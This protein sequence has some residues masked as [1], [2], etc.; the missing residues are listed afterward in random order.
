[1]ISLNGPSVV[2]TL[3]VGTYSASLVDAEN[4]V[5]DYKVFI[6]SS[7][8]TS[9]ASPLA[10]SPINGTVTPENN[11]FSFDIT[12]PQAKGE[13][14]IHINCTSGSYYYNKVHKIYV[15]TP[16]SFSVDVNNPTNVEIKNAT[17]QFF[18][19]D[20]E[21]DKQVILSLGA[22]QSTQV[23]SEW[24]SKDK[25]PGWHTSKILIDLNGDGMIDTNVG[26][27][28]IDDRFYIEGS[29]NWIFALTVL[30]GLTALIIGF[31]YISK[32]KIK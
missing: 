21:F 1:M 20:V 13:L 31:G 15:V 24:I 3:R 9:G 10:D 18:V 30:V 14:N 11:T 19:D 4:R 28:I 2:G 17:V 25:T 29:T 8:N 16:I 12:A 5:W 23:S 26:D 27:K 22:G 6:T 32:R 7:S